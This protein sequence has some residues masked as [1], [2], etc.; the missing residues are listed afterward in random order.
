[1]EKD[2]RHR[3]FRSHKSNASKRGIPFKLTFEQWWELWEPHWEERGRNKGC[4][5]MCRYL[6]SGGYEVGNVRIDTVAANADERSLVHKTSR[7]MWHRK[8]L[9]ERSTGW[10]GGPILSSRR[11][12]RPDE[13]YINKYESD[14][15]KA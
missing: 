7:L 10:T 3:K 2:D 4:K 6:D 9:S 8:A 1:M 13:A 15:E 12:D 5:V 14:Y 11:F